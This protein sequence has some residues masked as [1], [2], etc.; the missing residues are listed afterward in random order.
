[1]K[2]I[3]LANDKISKLL[4]A[5]SV[6]CIISMLV[7]AF[8][9]IIDQIFIGKGVGTLGNAATNV[10]FPLIMFS[11]ALASLVGN[12][13]AAYLSLKMGEGKKDEAKKSIGCSFILLCLIG[14]LVLVVGMFLLPKL[15]YFFGCTESVYPYAMTY[16]K[17]ILI[18]SLFSIVYTGMASII[19]ACGDPRYSM[20]CLVSGALL[21]CALDPIFIFGFNMG[22]AGGALATVIGQVVSF[23]LSVFYIP[24]MKTFKLKKSDFKLNK[25]AF[26]IISLGL[27]SFITQMTVVALFIVMNNLMTKYGASSIYG[28]DI[29]LSVY[30]VMSKL[31]SVYVNFILGVSLGAQPIIGFNYGAGNYERVKEVLRRVLVI[32]LIV[33]VIFNI[34]FYFFTSTLVSIFISSNDSTYDLFME[35]AI[36][37]SR[38]FYLV[39]ALNFF[40]MT[41]SIVIQSLGNVKKATAVSFARQIILFIPLAIILTHFL[42]LKGALYAAPIADALCFKFAI[43][44][45]LSEYKKL[46]KVNKS[47]I[48]EEE[49]NTSKSLTNYVIVISREYGSGG[50]YVGKLLA[51]K[52]SIPFYDK[53][54]IRMTA[55]ISGLNEEYIKDNEES[56]NLYYEQ[57]NEIFLAESK[58]IKDLAKK[59]C[60]I[61][62]RCADYILENNKNVF[63]V[64]LYSDEA[65]KLE[66]IKKYYHE[67]KP[68][69]VMKKK[70]KERSKH[71]KYYTGR[72]WKNY[73]NYDMAIHVDKFGVENVSQM[74]ADLLK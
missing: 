3:D 73:E 38:T 30:G 61:V 39:C 68:I 29:P 26:K 59:P 7:N 45:F 19:R 37:F 9:N 42:G 6:P 36:L 15:I 46:D 33:G 64:F 32:G 16:G 34:L 57:N 18:G 62:G 23:L 25:S 22:V 1:M 5:F 21:N 17:I 44:V 70:D 52:L 13:C 11:S 2:K 56:N 55:H 51:E 50:H 67:D 66:R 10:I 43:F 4:V 54:I 71:Y 47:D 31:N 41:T 28:S 27:S 63:K 69:V 40:E 8:Y 14:I 49:T 74:L 60:V 20:I 72:D 48:H 53:E 24:R 12:G 58:V 35:F 65:S